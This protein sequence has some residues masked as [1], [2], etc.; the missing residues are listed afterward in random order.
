ME[1]E[2][3]STKPGSPTGFQVSFL[4]RGGRYQGWVL[5]RREREQTPQLYERI[6]IN[7]THPR[8]FWHCCR[9]RQVACRVAGGGAEVKPNSLSRMGC[10]ADKESRFHLG[11][12]H[13]GD[14]NSPS[15]SSCADRFPPPRR[16]AAGW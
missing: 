8:K 11:H 16:I 6:T 10:V 7:S 3:D 5:C 14:N 15:K 9:V 12:S 2:D 13:D 4:A 1:S